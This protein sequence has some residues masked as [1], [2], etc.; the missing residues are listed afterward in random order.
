VQDRY[1]RFARHIASTRAPIRSD[2]RATLLD[3]RADS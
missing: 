2:S 1:G 3:S